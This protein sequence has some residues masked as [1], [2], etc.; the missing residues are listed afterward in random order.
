M[1]QLFFI[2]NRFFRSNI[3]LILLIV[4]F[5]GIF[6]Y[7]LLFE[8]SIK[9]GLSPTIIPI[10][11][12]I[13]NEKLYLDKDTEL[14]IG[15]NL[16]TTSGKPIVNT[17]GNQVSINSGSG[18]I[19]TLSDTVDPNS[20]AYDKEIDMQISTY[21]PKPEP[22]PLQIQVN[23]IIESSSNILN[24]I[25]APSSPVEPNYLVLGSAGNQLKDKNGKPLK[26]KSMKNTTTA[27]LSDIPNQN[28]INTD[29]KAAYIIE[30]PA[31]PKKNT[32]K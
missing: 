25:G 23:G 18:K 17:S 24:I 29:E 2:N 26:I 21:K 31:K 28:Y 6:L 7:S 9:E 27:V 15:D 11:A 22:L 20:V 1:K 10:K 32:K 19:Y 16:Q 8:R 30:E 4:F 5:G 14:S 13:V 12:K 3:F